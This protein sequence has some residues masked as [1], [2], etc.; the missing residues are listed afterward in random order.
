MF[1]PL[2]CSVV[3]AF[4]VSTAKVATV[5]LSVKVSKVFGAPA[6]SFMVKTP[7][8]LAAPKVTIGLVLEKINGEAADKVTVDP[9][10]APLPVT[11]YNL[12]GSLI[13]TLVVPEK[14]ISVPAVSKAAMFWNVGAAAAPEVK[15]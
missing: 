12:E 2:S 9:V 1:T 14:E 13:V 7:A 10:D 8:A 3:S 15:T 11:V 4:M 6:E 5:P